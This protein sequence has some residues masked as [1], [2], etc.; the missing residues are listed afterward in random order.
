MSRDLLHTIGNTWSA[1]AIFVLYPAPLRFGD[2]KRR[3]DDMGP[4]LRRTAISHKVLAETLRGLRRNGLVVRSDRATAA[5]AE[6]SL[7]PLGRSFWH[8]MMAVH[9]WTTKHIDKIEAARDRFDSE[10]EQDTI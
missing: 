8:P 9:H 6:Y 3:M 7:T 2:I 5:H 1:L 10:G 4:R